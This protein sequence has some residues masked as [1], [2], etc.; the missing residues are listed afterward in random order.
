MYALVG[1]DLSA[2]AEPSPVSVVSPYRSLGLYGSGAIAISSFIL[3]SI[4]SF[5]VFYLSLSLSFFCI[6]SLC[7]PFLFFF[8]LFFVALVMYLPLFRLFLFSSLCLVFSS[9]RAV[10]SAGLDCSIRSP[11][12]FPTPVIL[13][14]FVCLF[15]R[16]PFSPSSSNSSIERHQMSCINQCRLSVIVAPVLTQTLH[17]WL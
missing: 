10:R 13:F 14:V 4:S 8:F 15:F 12:S 17:Y 11:I 6:L 16:F 5:S 1:G 3:L 2:D 9:S 7:C